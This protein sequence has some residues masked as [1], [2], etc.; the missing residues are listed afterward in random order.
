M[1][2]N[3]PSI[4]F[5]ARANLRASYSVQEP[6][7]CCAFVDHPRHH[8]SWSDLARARS[9]L[10][11]ARPNS[12]HGQI[13]PNQFWPKP[14][15]SSPLLPVGDWFVRE[16]RRQAINT[17]VTYELTKLNSETCSSLYELS[18]LLGLIVKHSF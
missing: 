12:S 7:P 10:A 4:P 6:A 16:Y 14:L 13:N 8:V 11:M 5:S 15:P 1:D 3:R 17:S 2:P 9:S 18:K